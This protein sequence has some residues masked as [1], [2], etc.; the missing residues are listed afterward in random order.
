MLGTMTTAS[1]HG[2]NL[3]NH[4]LDLGGSESLTTLRKW[5]ETSH[6]LDAHYHTCSAQELTYEG[7]LQFLLERGKIEITGDRIFVIAEHVCTHDH[8]HTDSSHAVR[9]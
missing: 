9:G 8:E 5:A 2:H 3:L 6:G 7:L 1:I 4:I